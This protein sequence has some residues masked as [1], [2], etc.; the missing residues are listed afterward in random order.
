MNLDDFWVV[1]PSLLWQ[2]GDLMQTAITLMLYVRPPGSF[3][4]DW[5]LDGVQGNLLRGIDT[6]TVKA[7]T[8][9]ERWKMK[10]DTRQKSSPFTKKKTDFLSGISSFLAILHMLRL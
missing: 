10:R 7:V 2:L 8:Y 4:Y 9:D 5:N 1:H 6:K 3:F